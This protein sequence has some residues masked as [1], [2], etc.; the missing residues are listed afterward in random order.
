MYVFVFRVF[1]ENIVMTDQQLSLQ[2][3]PVPETTIMAATDVTSLSI[4]NGGGACAAAAYQPSSADMGNKRHSIGSIAF[5]LWELV[6]TLSKLLNWELIKP[7]CYGSGS[8]ELQCIVPVRV[9]LV[10][11]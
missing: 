8:G 4:A 3:C 2:P 10:R 11:R 5:G 6:S 9:K 7:V 1:S